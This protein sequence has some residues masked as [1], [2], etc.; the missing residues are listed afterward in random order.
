MKVAEIKV[1]YNTSFKKITKI[2]SSRNAEQL[3]RNYWNSNTLELYEEV[4]VIFLNKSNIVLGIYDL[5]KGGT[6]SS[7]VDIKIILSIALKCVASGLILVHN[8]PSGNT[9]PSKSDLDITQKLK[10]GGELLDI[11]LLDHLIITKSSYMSFADD[12]LL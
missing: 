4:K 6:S 5:S 2:T 12:G 1:S 10:K 11:T 7:I 8:H 3:M 9:A